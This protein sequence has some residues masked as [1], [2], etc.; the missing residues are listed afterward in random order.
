MD[1]NELAQL[2]NLPLEVKILKTTQRI[3][4]WYEHY[5]GN[6]YISFSG[7]KDS[8]VLLDI[9]RSIYPDIEAVFIDTGMEY[10]EIKKFVKT[11]DNVIT[12]HPKYKFHEVIEKYGYPV[13]SKEQSQFIYQYRTAKSEKTKQTRLY[14]NKY[15][16]GKISNKWKFLL[17]KDYKISDECCNILKKNPVKKYEKETGNKGMIGIMAQESSKRVQDYLKFGCNAFEA[18]RPIS[19]PLGF[20]KEQDILEYLYTKKIGYATCY[21]DI[22]YCSNSGMYKTTGIERSGCIGCIYGAHL[23]KEPNRFQKMKITHPNQYKYFI[24]KLGYRQILDDIG[25]K[26]GDYIEPK[27][28]FDIKY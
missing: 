25:I 11:I 15:G 7:G 9:A 27:K 21:G 13:I 17:E 6:V 3:R 23:E 19:R 5:Q 10:P 20:W 2:Q 12:L 4:E 28:L 1:S 22:I 26:Y 8:T 24:D 18:K 14:G 16:M